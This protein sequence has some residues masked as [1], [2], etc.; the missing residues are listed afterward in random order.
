[1]VI[2]NIASYGLD[3]IFYLKK[4][5]DGTTG[6]FKVSCMNEIRKKMLTFII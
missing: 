5:S 2:F 4:N 6:K 1:M 3:L